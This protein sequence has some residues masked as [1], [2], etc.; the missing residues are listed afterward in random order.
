MEVQATTPEVSEE[1]TEGVIDES[2]E[3]TSA[4]SEEEITQEEQTQLNLVEALTKS[5]S[6]PKG[7]EPFQDEDGTVKFV[8]PIDGEKYIVNFNQLLSGFNLNQAGEKKLKE[9]KALEKQL[10]KLM[11][12]LSP[13]NPESKKELKK[14][15]TK[16]GHNVGDLGEDFL[17]EAVA[18]QQM[19][20][21]ERELKQRIA[22]IEAREAKLNESTM[23]AKEQ[24][25][26]AAIKTKQ[27]AY[28]KEII[29]AL[30]SK[31][32]NDIDPILKQKLFVKVT[33]E[34]MN[35]V[36]VDSKLSAVDALD[37]VLTEYDLLLENAS[38]LYGKEHL[39]KRIPAEFKKLINGMTLEEKEQMDIISNS[40]T[41]GPVDLEGYE[42]TRTKKPRK[43][44]LLSEW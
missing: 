33:Q 44:L 38:K 23:T 42:D 25:E 10:N 5:G 21:Q 30:E 39:K 2:Q 41:G 8:M 18:E 22:D 28:S 11:G 6:I 3:A 37:N 35:A 4:V 20:P 14:F 15:L 40:V 13:S 16:L 12:D 24:E 31:V 17:S 19:T 27:E 1:A 26:R 43:K 32:S 7:V 36:R 29:T 9:G 34:M